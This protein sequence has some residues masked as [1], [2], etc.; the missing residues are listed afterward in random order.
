MEEKLLYANNNKIKSGFILIHVFVAGQYSANLRNIIGC[1]KAVSHEIF[2][3]V[4]S[5]D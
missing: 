1:I 3:N 5:R 2:Y 4:E